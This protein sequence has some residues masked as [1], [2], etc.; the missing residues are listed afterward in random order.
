MSSAAERWERGRALFDAA[1]AL[2]PD[3]RG[4][5]LDAACDDDEQRAEIAALLH[6]HAAIE[7]GAVT[8]FL[9]LDPVNTAALLDSTDSTGEPV[10]SLAPGETLGRYR[11]IR[12]VGAGGMGVVYLAEDERL[13]RAAALKLL[14]RR[15]AVDATARRRFEEEARAASALD[16]PNIVTVYEL[17]DTPD[18]QLFLA[19]AYCEGETLSERLKRGRL[20]IADAQSLGTQITAGLAAAHRGGIVH[21]DIKPRNIVIT[22]D[23]TAKIVDFGVA[24]MVGDAPSHAPVTPGTLAYMSPEQTRGDG[25]DVRA[26]VWAL[27]A[28]LYE[29]IAGRRPFTATEAPQLIHAIRSAAP[30]PLAT[31]RPDVPAGLA[32]I[33]ERCLSKQPSARYRD[34]GAVLSALESLSAPRRSRA[35]VALMV[36]VALVVLGVAVGLPM[37]AA[38]PP[39]DVRRVA[40]ADIENRSG[41]AELDMHARMATDWITRGLWETGFIGAVPLAAFAGDPDA[42]SPRRMART[43]G[44][45][46]LVAGALYREGDRVQLEAQITHVESGLVVGSVEPVSTSL[47]SVMDGIEQLRR[48]VQ[49]TLYPQLDTQLTHV[50]AVARVPR[51]EAYAE[52]LAGRDAHAM[53]RLPAALAHFRRASELDPEFLLPRVI[54]ALVLNMMDD[55]PAADSVLRVLER[56]RAQLDRFSVAH[57]DWLQ[58]GRDGDVRAAHAAMSEA[59]MLAPG[60]TIPAVQ[61]A[62]EALRL[63]RAREAVERLTAIEPERGELRGW[64]YYWQNLGL[65]YHLDGDHR[66]EL[67]AA[68]RARA[69]YPQDPRARMLELQA[70]AALGHVNA[71]EEQLDNPPAT[72]PGEPSRGALLLHTA[73]ELRAHAPEGLAGRRRASTRRAVAD[74]LLAQAIAWYRAVP[75]AGRTVRQH[76]ELAIALAAAGRRAE[77][78]R[79]LAGLVHAPPAGRVDPSPFASKRVPNYPDSVAIHGALGVLAALD[80]DRNATQAEIAWLGQQHGPLARGRPTYWR[81][82]IAGAQRRPEDAVAL[83]RTAFDEGLP[84]FH[85]LHIAPELESIRG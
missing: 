59:A 8:G 65:A 47:A 25:S 68:R 2:P 9:E 21:G 40:I 66:P 36:A 45:G 18:E 63:G 62:D 24:K 43:A 51:F 31:V 12:R 73:L 15:L 52:Y 74:T 16:H 20:A 77:A 1:R 83:L 70:L 57:L 19:M 7:S 38:D 29:M 81:A 13:H 42:G 39:L 61:A 4:A 82:A 76:H 10:D 69:L 44:A 72:G 54:E 28:V 67:A 64:F 26:D 85:G 6:A 11:V 35:R 5:Y 60:S 46:L 14:P 23:G 50:Q 33:V 56:E 53:R 58:A 80:G 41:A 79:Y 27:G 22:T 55:R 3:A 34:A 17:G 49:E 48:R 30:P 71:I 78:R 32:R 37:I 84:R 75:P